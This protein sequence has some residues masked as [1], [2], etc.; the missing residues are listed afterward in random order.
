MFDKNQVCEK[1]TELNPD[2]GVCGIDIETFYSKGRDSWVIVSKKGDHET[3]HFLD[4]QDI[5]KC[6]DDVQ[7]F[8][9]GI[10]ISQV[11]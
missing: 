11:T 9:L 4:K 5:K 2:F 3:V 7:C 8:S 10:D 6:L 1:I